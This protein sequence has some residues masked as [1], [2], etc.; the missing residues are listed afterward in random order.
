MVTSKASVHDKSAV[1]WRFD[2]TYARLPDALFVPATPARVRDPRVS[3][4]NHRLADELGL[5]VVVMRPFAEGGLLRRLVGRDGS[6]EVA[7]ILEVRRN[8]P[9]H[10]QAIRCAAMRREV[11]IR[12]LGAANLCERDCHVLQSLTP[13]PEPR[14][15]LGA[16]T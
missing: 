14:L 7:L 11:A 9:H 8:A 12:G 6:R 5:G 1:G 16:W 4:L 10:R 13:Q 2:N 15:L 3:V